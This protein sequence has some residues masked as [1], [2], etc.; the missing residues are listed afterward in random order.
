M[1]KDQTGAVFD[2]QEDQFERFDDIFTHL[3]NE[4]RINFEIGRCKALPEL[5]E[6]DVP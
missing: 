3:K 6:D 5:K 1:F 4:G 2:V